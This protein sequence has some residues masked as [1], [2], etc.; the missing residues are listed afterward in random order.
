MKAGTV[1]S[2]GL[3]AQGTR[4]W[5]PMLFGSPFALA[6]AYMLAIALA[7]PL[8]TERG[9]TDHAQMI[10]VLGGDGPAR[11]ARAAELWH[12]DIAPEVLIAGDGDCTHIRDA[13][14]AGGVARDVIELECLSGNTRQNALFSAPILEAAEIRSAVLV[15]SWFHTRR[16]MASFRAVCPGIEWTSMPAEPPGRLA[17]FAF[18]QYGSAIILEY[19]K[20]VAYRLADLVDGDFQGPGEGVCRVRGSER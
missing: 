14:V 16:A 17:E 7:D 8:L 4:W 13:M 20:L 11:A 1:K 3:A 12:A 9:Q 10:V 15:T 2:T 5:L 18:G 6:M 19:V